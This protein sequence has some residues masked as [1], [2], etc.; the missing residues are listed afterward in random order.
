MTHN[1][2]T[3][4]RSTSAHN[5]NPGLQVNPDVIELTALSKELREIKHQLCSELSQPNMIRATLEGRFHYESENDPGRI[6]PAPL[7]GPRD[8]DSD[9][10]TATVFCM[11]LYILAEGWNGK[12]AQRVEV[13]IPNKGLREQVAGALH[14]IHD[15]LMI[16]ALLNITRPF[17]RELND[18]EPLPPTDKE[19]VRRWIYEFL[20]VCEEATDQAQVLDTLASQVYVTAD[21]I[22]EE[23]RDL[24]AVA[25]LAE[26]APLE[27]SKR[28]PRLRMTIQEANA[29]AMRLAKRNHSFVRL[30]LRQWA[31][32]IGCS[33]GLVA[34]LPFWRTT[35]EKTGRGKNNRET[36]PKAS[37]F[38]P[39][40]EAVS[41]NGEGTELCQLKRLIA[42]QKADA[43]PSPLEDDLS[44]SPPKRVRFTKR[45]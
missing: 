21:H 8:Q 36:G 27:E 29:K 5:D 30:G 15:T 18:S 31:E 9:L 13:A 40:L 43:E 39:E 11:W 22:R 1:R 45:V 16:P 28:F 37:S 26:K 19:T 14:R 12:L 24:A 25:R 4:I 17:R 2:N 23:D 42:E 35:M 34:K 32:A 10:R 33:E 6:L 7:P 38:T 20:D 3:A 41:R 44:D